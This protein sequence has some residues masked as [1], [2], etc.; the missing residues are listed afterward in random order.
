MRIPGYK[1][2]KRTV[3]WTYSRFEQRALILGY[4]RIVETT[5]DLYGI[6]V[7]PVH[8]Q[9]QMEV[10]KS[11]ANPI[12]LEELIAS[13]IK[14]RFPKHSV[15]VTFDDGYADLFHNVK[16]VLEYYQVPCTAFIVTGNIGQEFWWDELERLARA[17]NSETD[18]SIIS[19]YNQ[20]LPLS[21]NERRR[22]LWQYQMTSSSTA[23][24]EPQSRAL[25][26]DELV[27]FASGDLVEIGSHGINHVSLERL[28]K[29]GQQI[30]LAESK[31]FLEGLLHKSI[32]SVSYPNGSFSPETLELVRQTGYERACS[33]K[34]GVVLPRTDPYKLPRFWVPNLNGLAF[35]RWLLSWL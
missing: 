35:K 2:V 10:L 16:P 17:R 26:V 33:N 1:T 3:H 9:E 23:E 27:E 13:L 18:A 28:P 4:H 5:E 29:E 31:A 6:C 7:T 34:A 20:L 24:R 25:T 19:L 22:E 14:G 8:F 12:R 21:P 15:V 32:H 30:E 11:L